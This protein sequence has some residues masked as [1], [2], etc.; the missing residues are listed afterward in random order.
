[1]PPRSHGS[2]LAGLLP[3]P[4]KL[5]DSERQALQAGT[6]WADGE[7]FSGR[8]DF[9]ALAATPYPD[10]TA[11]ERQFLSGPVREVCERIDD[12]EIRRRQEIPEEIWALLREHGFFGLLIPEAWGGLGFSPLAASTVFATLATRSLAVSAVVLIPN[13]VGPG[14]LLLSHGTD[15]QR[16]RLLPRLARG[17]EIPCFAL[18]EPQAGSDAASLTSRARVV[19]HPDDPDGPPYLSLDFDKRYITLA[20]VATLLGLAVRLEDPDH[21]LGKD[22][23]PGITVVLVPADAPGVEVG[24]RHDPLGLAFPNG[25]VSGRGVMV[26]ADEAI[27]GGIGP[28]GGAGRGWGMLMEALAAGRSVSLPAQ[29]VGGLQGIARVTGAYAAVR[30]QFGRPI[31]EFEGIAEPLARIAG[32]AYLGEAVRVATCGALAAGHRPA[33]VGALVKLRTT[34]LLRARAGDAMDVVAGAGI[35]QGPRNLVARAWL[36]APVGITV[37]G[38]NILTRT[39][40]VFGQGVV[41]A[42]PHVRRAMDAAEAGRP[43]ALAGAVG[44]HLLSTVGHALAVATLG[45]SRRT[46]SDVR[47]PARRWV[48]PLGRASAVFALLTDLALLSLGSKLKR[49]EALSGRFADALSWIYCGW[50]TVRRFE[51]EGR[52]PEDRPLLDWCLATCLTEVQ[53]AF[54]GIA[55]NFS[56]SLAWPVRLVLRRWLR[57]FPVGRPPSDRLGRKVAR[58]LTRPGTQRDR[59]TGA[60]FV[61]DDPDDPAALLERAFLAVGSGSPD[62]DDLRR[63]VIQ[64]DVFDRLPLPDLDQP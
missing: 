46:R 43:L 22:P 14:E 33:V 37:E 40:I 38:A 48:R 26:P 49:H 60:V 6:V 57:L 20:P 5:S 51:A 34:E 23:E 24:R 3:R 29:S 36:G 52:R 50:C 7:I 16:R 11:R 39:L 53:T 2:P 12:W 56:G 58:I 61:S 55:A 17:E 15:E 10:L 42:H 47:G 54:E 1:M 25:P 18:T 9:R 28:E 31:A 45:R 63:R 41:R 13:S 44:R 59:L 35:C 64:V 62:A 21:L 19:P 8:P 4:P 27:L 32:A 30:H